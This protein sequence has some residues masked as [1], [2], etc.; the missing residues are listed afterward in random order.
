MTCIADWRTSSRI[1]CCTDY[2][3]EKKEDGIALT[4]F[5]TCAEIHSISYRGIIMRERSVASRD[6]RRL[7]ITSLCRSASTS[8]LSFRNKYFF[9]SSPST[10]SLPI[11]H[12][13]QLA[14]GF[15]RISS[16]S[17]KSTVS[18]TYK[19]LLCI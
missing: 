6:K 12:F 3:L 19:K 7:M 11:I 15:T 17:S 8:L 16:C 1:C 5:E 14:T 10:L 2:K 18:L 13:C 9:G 4:Y